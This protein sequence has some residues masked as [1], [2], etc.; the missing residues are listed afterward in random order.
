MKC[1][2]WISE[3]INSPVTQMIARKKALPLNTALL[4]PS[5][6]SHSCPDLFWRF[7]LLPQHFCI[8]CANGKYDRSLLFILHVLCKVLISSSLKELGTKSHSTECD[9]PQFQMIPIYF[10]KILLMKTHCWWRVL[11]GTWTSSSIIT[12]ICSQSLASPQTHEL[13]LKNSCKKS[14]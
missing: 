9:A 1:Q 3:L 5:D 4:Q 8:T 10:A 13:G 7:S 11:K 2:R 14:Y 12:A 6:H